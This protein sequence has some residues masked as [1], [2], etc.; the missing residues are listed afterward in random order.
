MACSYF[1]VNPEQFV[2]QDDNGCAWPS[3]APVLRTLHTYFDSH[4]RENA[5]SLGTGMLGDAADADAEA[6]CSSYQV[7]LRPV[8]A[9]AAAASGWCRCV[10][11]S[12]HVCVSVCVCV[13]VCRYQCRCECLWA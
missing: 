11:V 3:S 6:F 2:L 4:P 12:V 13:C 7:H 5:L 9:A 10:D 8:P 1:G